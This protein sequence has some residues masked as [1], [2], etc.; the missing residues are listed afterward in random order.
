[1]PQKLQYVLITGAASGV[2]KATCLYL[3]SLGFKLIACDINLVALNELQQALEELVVIRADITDDQSVALLFDQVSHLV[4][5]AGLYGLINSAGVLP[6]GPVETNSMEEINLAFQVN[7]I[8]QIRII[9]KFLPLIRMGKGRIIFMSSIAGIIPSFTIM[10]IYSATKHALE[11]ICDLLRVELMPWK[12][13]VIAIEANPIATPLAVNAVRFASFMQ[14]KL[15]ADLYDLYANEIKIAEKW[16][17]KNLFSKLIKPETIAFCCG[18]AL[19]S[20]HPKSRYMICDY[21]VR[22]LIKIR[23]ILPDKLYDKLIRVIMKYL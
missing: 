10:G 7:S 13:P 23:S 16:Y 17:N 22:L 15:T 14:E 5:N 6:L 18:R 1:M 12:I 11:C 20:K 2:G 19:T 8:G 3:H 9:K 4:G 21:K